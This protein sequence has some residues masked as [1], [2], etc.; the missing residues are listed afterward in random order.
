MG[1]DLEN[2]HPLSGVVEPDNSLDVSIELTAPDEPGTYLGYWMLEN[3]R[4]EKFG[5]GEDHDQAF[6]V[7]IQ[8]AA[9][10]G[11]SDA[12]EDDPNG[13][14][15]DEEADD[16]VEGGAAI[17]AASLNVSPASYTGECPVTLEFSGS[18]TSSGAGNY[19]YQ[20]E[21]GAGSSGFQFFLP[22]PQDVRY[23]GGEN[24]LPINF[25]LQIE[26]S[27]DG[28]AQLVANGSNTLRSNQAVFSVT[29]E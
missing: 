1:A 5:L 25:V 28:W 29:C 17:T 12:E 13:T 2:T 18:I 22:E 20:V 3:E 19:V 8:V 21:A 15:T 10:G 16:T 14:E 27:V 9:D 4:G 23:L 24:T 11:A 7:M 26:N 6:F